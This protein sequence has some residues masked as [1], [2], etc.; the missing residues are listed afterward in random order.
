MTN[1]KNRPTYTP[2]YG[3]ERLGAVTRANAYMASEDFGAGAEPILTIDSIGYGDCQM[4]KSSATET[5]DI[6]CFREHSAPGLPVV[7]PMVCNATNRKVLL[8]LYGDLTPG[9]LV[10]K[11][12]RLFVDPRVKAIGGGTTSGI[13][14]RKMIPEPAP[15]Q[16]MPPQ[17]IPDNPVPPA[18]CQHCGRPV[19]AVPNGS[20][21]EVLRYGRQRW[22][23]DLC[24]ECQSVLMAAEQMPH[25]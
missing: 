7:R 4:G 11:R 13:R 25:N 8:A 12:V 17:L 15:A 23:A 5:K 6:I 9:V 20:Y 19:A 1:N 14:I 10:G 18:I 16:Q 3:E 21:E 2:Y 24:A 22:N